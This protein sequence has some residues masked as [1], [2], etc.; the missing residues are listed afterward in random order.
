M[1]GSILL[2]AS[3]VIDLFRGN[4]S[5]LPKLQSYQKF[6]LPVIVLGELYYGAHRSGK[7]SEKVQEIERFLGD[8]TLLE[9]TSD[10]AKHYASIKNE[11][12][13]QGKPI[14]E[15]DIWIAA[16]AKEYGLAIGTQDKHFDLIAGLQVDSF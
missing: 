10:T 9:V 6:Y 14:P 1:A 4:Q 3:V 15:N 5:L 12:R 16:L 7:L 2:D 13:L 8:V 11:L